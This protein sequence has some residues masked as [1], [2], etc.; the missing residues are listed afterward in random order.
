MNKI[1]IIMGKS[2]TGKSTIYMLLKNKLNGMH[3][4]IQGTTRPKRS[5]ELSDGEYVFVTH[6]EFERLQE[7][8]RVLESREYDTVNGIWTYFTYSDD[9][10]LNQ[11]NYMTIGTIETYKKL[12]QKFKREQIVPIL[13]TVSNEAELAHRLIE[14]EKE[15]PTDER[16]FSEVLRRY[17]ADRKD[18]GFFKTLGIR[19]SNRHNYGLI[20]ENESLVPIDVTVDKI[21]DYINKIDNLT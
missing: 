11:Y 3:E 16:D 1:Y 12:V 9:I 19:L 15:K 18:F 8:G 7:T 20:I 17:N 10:D 13:L 21:C 5:N 6:S 4:L 14:R 2:G